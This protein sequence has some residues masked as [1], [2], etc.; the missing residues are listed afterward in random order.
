MPKPI[1]TAALAG[2]A[3]LSAIALN[4][5]ATFA[6]TG[7]YSAASDEA[8]VSAVYLVSG[9]VHGL[10]YL[11]FAGVLRVFGPRVD[12]GS[13]FRRIVRLTLIVVFLVLAGG[14]LVNTAVSA[15]T[16]EM[17]SGD[18]P[19]GV[20]AGISFLLH[21]LGSVALGFGLLRRPGMRL[22]AWT[23]IAVLPAVGLTILL[24]VLGSPWAHPAYAE[25]LVCFGIA[26]IGVSSG[27]ATHP[28]G[29]PEP[30]LDPVRG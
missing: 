6:L 10:A 20:V 8:G 17:L 4:D 25:A 2:A 13:R 21:F 14:M 12:G 5:A 1:T 18:G 16:G 19:Y 29:A 26:F 3:G 7:H 22:P 24:G 28:M 9:L 11:A 27:R 15:V 23:L 30:L